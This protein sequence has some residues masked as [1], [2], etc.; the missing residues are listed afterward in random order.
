M[1]KNFFATSERGALLGKEQQ[2]RGAGGRLDD[3][4]TT[5]LGSRIIDL[6]HIAVYPPFFR[7]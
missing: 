6:S 4:Q 3:S 5:I 1:A 2:D 7:E